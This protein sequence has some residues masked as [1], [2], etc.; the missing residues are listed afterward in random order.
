MAVLSKECVLLLLLFKD[1]ICLSLGLIYM[2]F[3]AY[4]GIKSLKR[5]ERVMKIGILRIQSLED[6]VVER[7]A[8]VKKDQ[9]RMVRHN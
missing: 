4:E 7:V 3:R 2:P 8:T 1:A 5:F 9:V 6:H